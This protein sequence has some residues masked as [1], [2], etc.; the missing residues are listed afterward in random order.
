MTNA[1]FIQKGPEPA[2]RRAR[3]EK[4]V[5]GTQASHERADTQLTAMGGHNRTNPLF[6]LVTRR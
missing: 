5:I 2:L 1:G 6:N 3:L 4:Q